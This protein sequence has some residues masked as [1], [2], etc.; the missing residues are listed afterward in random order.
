MRR[1]LL[2]LGA[3]VCGVLALLQFAAAQGDSTPSSVSTAGASSYAPVGGSSALVARGHELFTSSCAAC[4]GMG[5]QG[6]RGRGP[7]LHGVGALA[8][9][10]YLQTGRMPLPSPRVQPQRAKPAFPQS[11][12]RALVAYVASFG[13]PA[14]PVVQPSRGSLP[15]GQRLFSLSCAGCHTIQGQGGIVTGAIAPSLDRSTPTQV[16]QAIR[17]GP[18]VMPRF[19]EGEL[20]GA[21]VD[22]LARYVQSLQHPDDRGGWAIGRIGPIPEGMVAWLLAAAALLLIAR[23]LGERTQGRTRGAEQGRG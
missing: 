6:I 5:A 20:S 22:S 7:S 16:A 2:A 3:L 23:L 8:A 11:Q 12:I 13:G 14:I 1:R 19:G 10:F 21:Q 9:D 17:I 15:E 4:H 18:Y